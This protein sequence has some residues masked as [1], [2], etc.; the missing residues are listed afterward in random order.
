MTISIR[1]ES[2]VLVADMGKLCQAQP[3]LLG[4]GDNWTN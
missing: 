2:M 1:R 3:D 4:L